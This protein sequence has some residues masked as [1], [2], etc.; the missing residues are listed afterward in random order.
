[1][2]YVFLSQLKG[3]KHI[4]VVLFEKESPTICSRSSHLALGMVH[5]VL[6]FQLGRQWNARKWYW[7]PVVFVVLDFRGEFTGEIGIYMV[8][9]SILHEV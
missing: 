1:M 8:F 9:T 4:F 3:Y 5:M 6:E 7:L 2:G